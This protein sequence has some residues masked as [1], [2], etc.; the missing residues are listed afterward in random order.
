[1]NIKG[2][3]QDSFIKGGSQQIA[4]KMAK[5]IGHS[6]ILIDSPVVSIKY[7]DKKVNV[8]CMKKKT[9]SMI[10]AKHCIIALSPNLAGRIHYEPA[11]PNLR[12]QLTQRMPGGCVYKIHIFY[13]KNFWRKS[14]FS[15]EVISLKGPISLVY[16][17]SYDGLN[18]LVAFVAGSTAR[19]WSKKSKE[20]R[21]TEALKQLED[22]FNTKDA[23]KPLN[24]VEMDWTGEKYSRGCY[25]CVATPGT[26]SECGEA[27]RK[28]IGPIHFAG[29]ETAINYF[30]YME[31]A[32]DAGIRVANEVYDQFNVKSKL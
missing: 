19:N 14:K 1:M 12:D 9:I 4:K 25:F 29:S 26:I 6:K 31:G 21:K 3:A 16:D 32:L 17:K 18:C 22:L 20:E 23:S 15:G 7:T 11:L 13:K 30:G 5:E 8:V 28:S 24:Y 10:R 27:L 2:G